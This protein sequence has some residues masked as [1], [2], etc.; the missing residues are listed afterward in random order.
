MVS[1]RKH[2]QGKEGGVCL[3]TDVTYTL[4]VCTMYACGGN[5]SGDTRTHIYLYGYARIS[6]I[7]NI[8]KY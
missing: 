8:T 3:S 2:I 1:K 4:C 6:N 5:G 7:T